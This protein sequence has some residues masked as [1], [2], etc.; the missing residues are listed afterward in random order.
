VRPKQ[1]RQLFL[2]PGVGIP[3]PAS[4]SA[5]VGPTITNVHVTAGKNARKTGEIIGSFIKHVLSKGG[6]NQTKAYL[7][8]HAVPAIA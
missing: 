2:W 8:G 3:D 6:L 5:R 1:V 4:G 7:G